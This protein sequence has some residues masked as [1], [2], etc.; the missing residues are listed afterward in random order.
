MGEEDRYRELAQRI[1]MGESPIIPR[2]FKMLAD[3]DEAELL[4]SMPGTADELSGKTGLGEDELNEILSTLY[5]K[6]LVFKKETPEGTIYRLCR[7]LMQFHDATILWP[8]APRDFLDLWQCFMEEEWP[9][10][11]ENVEKMLP[12]P[13][14]RIVPVMESLDARQ[15]ILAFEDVR[16][17]IEDSEVIAVTNCTCRLIA[18]KCDRP[19]EVCLQ[20]GKAGSYAIDRGSGRKIDKEEALE[21][22][23]KSEEAGLV[24]TT[25][26]RSSGMNFICNCCDDCCMVFPMLIDRKLN[27]CDPSRFRAR[28]DTGECNACGDCIERCYFGALSIDDDAGAAEV[29]A[30]ACM[31]CGLCEIVCPAGALSM[32]VVRDRDFIPAS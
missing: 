4:L 30:E 18:R 31:G 25:M 22:L 8:E 3:D 12:K 28:V 5:R 26:N 27:M 23:R 32:E 17:I 14:T 29:D 9:A 13:V 21:V 7:D 15:Q 1:F 19:L 11:S 16:Q 10:F 24:H 6:G 20:V 2:L